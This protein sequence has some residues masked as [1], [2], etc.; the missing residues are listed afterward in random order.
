MVDMAGPSVRS[1]RWPRA[2]V[3]TFAILLQLAV[4]SWG[5]ALPGAPT[6]LSIAFDEHALCRAADNGFPRLALLSGET[7]VGPRHKPGAFCCL[8]HQFAGVQ[9][10]AIFASH[11]RLLAR[12]AR[13][14]GLRTF[15]RRVASLLSPLTSRCSRHETPTSLLSP[16]VRWSTCILLLSLSDWLR[17]AQGNSYAKR[18][19]SAVIHFLAGG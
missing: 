7:P 3:G 13:Q 5:M 18:A 10:L 16:W 19:E 9:P 15:T 14:A 1:A 2:F 6:D 11:D 12:R 8:C 4:A 17:P